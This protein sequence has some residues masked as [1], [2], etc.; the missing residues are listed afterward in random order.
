MKRLFLTLALAV[1]SIFSYAGT[2]AENLI[3]GLPDTKGVQVIEATGFLMK[4]ARVAIRKTPMKPLA[5][6][7]SEVTL[8]QD[9]ER[10]NR[11]T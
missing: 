11:D 2:P 10:T 9:A 4:F 6:Q 8:L 3:K 5:E 7:V 1:A